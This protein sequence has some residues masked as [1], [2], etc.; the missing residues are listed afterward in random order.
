MHVTP[1]N[2]VDGYGGQ[3]IERREREFVPPGSA[4]RSAAAGNGEVLSGIAGQDIGDIQ[5]E[6][7]FVPAWWGG[8]VFA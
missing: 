5:T 3:R 8:G 2:E 4:L 1:V 7:T 6:D